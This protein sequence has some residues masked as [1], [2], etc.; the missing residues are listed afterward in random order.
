MDLRPCLSPIKTDK[1]RIG[2]NSDGGYVLGINYL[3]DT[4][5]SYGVGKN[6]KF[7]EHYLQLRPCAKMFLFD[8]TVDSLPSKMLEKNAM[9]KFCKKNVYDEKDLEI[10]DSGCLVMMDIERSEFNLIKSLTERTIEKI[11]QMCIEVHFHKTHTWK[12]SMGFFEIIN[13][14]F[15]LIHIHANNHK[16]RLHFGIPSVLELTL[17]NKRYFKENIVLEKNN[18]PIRGLDYPNIVN[19]TDFNLDWWAK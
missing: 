4:V 17:I 8:G 16:Q 12:D 19:K 9:V 11:K 5:Y 10:N 3:S 1:I 13:R 7:E 2:P 14:F 18:F 15:H 6:V